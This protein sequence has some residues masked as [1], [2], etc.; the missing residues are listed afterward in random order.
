MDKKMKQNRFSTFDKFYLNQL[1]FDLKLRN[2]KIRILLEK[3]YA[4]A[5][6]YFFNL[7]IDLIF[8]IF[9]ILPIFLDN[10][11]KVTS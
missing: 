7:K 4:F 5:L 9:K 8:N 2:L 11:G 1:K 10:E 6:I 3:M